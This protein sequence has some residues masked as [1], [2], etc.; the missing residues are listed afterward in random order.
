MSSEKRIIFRFTMKHTHSFIL[1]CIV[2]FGAGNIFSANVPTNKYEKKDSLTFYFNQGKSDI[3]Y[4][5]S[6]NSVE[7]Q[8]M[9]SLL[10]DNDIA[11]RNVQIIGSASPEGGISLNYK[12]SDQRAEKILSKLRNNTHLDPD[13]IK[14]SFVG[15]DWKRLLEFVESDPA[16]PYKAQTISLLEEI[17]AGL[18]TDT[19]E[20]EHAHNLQRLEKLEN[21]IPYAYLYRNVFPYLRASRLYFTTSIL[22]VFDREVKIPEINAITPDI[23]TDYL[24]FQ[25]TPSLKQRKNFYM[26][27]KTNMLYDILLLPSVSAEFYL[28][29]NFSTVANWMYGWWNKDCSHRYWRAYGGDLA[30]RWWF[31]HEANRKPLTGHQV[32]VYGGITTF[33]F[34]FGNKGYM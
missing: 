27:L 11:I 13:K 16:V 23:G 30:V 15:R 5:I 32:G 31:G 17:V 6:N 12:L 34:E 14:I 26:A 24:F 4:N 8:A 20:N 10:K 28:G 7:F 33:D 9:D 1:S 3:D 18:S 2:L 29:K 21:G 25:E 22:P 19:E